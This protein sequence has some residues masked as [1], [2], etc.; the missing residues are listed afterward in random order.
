MRFLLVPALLF[1]GLAQA[2]ESEGMYEARLAKL[3]AI[4]P[5]ASP[6]PE[7]NAFCKERF[8][9]WQG[10]PASV[11]W[12]IRAD[13]S[14]LAVASIKGIETELSIATVPGSFMGFAER[15]RLQPVDRIVFTLEAGARSGHIDVLLIG[16]QNFNCVLSNR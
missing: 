1:A 16:D 15:A 5:A 14:R 4:T 11:R 8:G 3:A 6:A 9:D 10:L 12:K 13:G 7:G 2:Q